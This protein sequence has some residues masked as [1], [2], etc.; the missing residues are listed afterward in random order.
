MAASTT[1]TTISAIPTEYET[2]T[3]SYTNRGY[4][5]DLFGGVEYDSDNW[6][7]STYGRIQSPGTGNDYYAC[8][9]T[10]NGIIDIYKD[11]SVNGSYGKNRRTRLGMAVLI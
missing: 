11:F 10:A 7:S 4:I 5:I 6:V 2:P 8:I 3:T 1:T 9:T